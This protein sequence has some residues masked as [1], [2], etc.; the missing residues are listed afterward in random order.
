MKEISETQSQLLRDDNSR[1]GGVACGALR[2]WQG[3]RARV[4]VSA[5]RA[6]Q[7]IWK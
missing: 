5:I 3:M 1:M 4:A 6:T 7:A 2:A